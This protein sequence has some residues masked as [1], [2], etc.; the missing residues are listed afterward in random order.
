MRYAITHVTHFAYDSPVSESHMEVRMQPRTD[1]RQTCLRY[2][3]HVEPR[4][5]P[6]T[7]HD[8]LSNWVDYFSVPRTHQSLT[9]TARADVQV[10]GTADLPRSLDAAAWQEVDDWS[11]QDAHWDLRHPSAFAVWTPALAAYAESIPAARARSADP[12]STA[13][14]ISAA[15]HRDF[16]YAPNSTKVNSA[17]DE[18]LGSRSGVCQDL[19]HIMVALLRRLDL[20]ARYISGYIAPA[21]NGPDADPISSATHAWVE[22]RL[23]QLG[24]VGFDPTNDI[25]AGERHIR[26]A[27]GRDYADVPPARGVC[28]GAAASTLT[29]S[30]AVRPADPSDALPLSIPGASSSISQISA[31]TNDSGQPSLQQ[32]QQQQ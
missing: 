30:V 12:L 8:H 29:V 10:H 31:R 7:F 1:D 22:V 28:K 6:H 27:I 23:P 19:S 5:R 18:A 17:I 9:I 16:V 2:D 20:P 14:D 15:V 21:P 13:R 25:E 4:A 26:V 24:W 32:R 3:L 11:R